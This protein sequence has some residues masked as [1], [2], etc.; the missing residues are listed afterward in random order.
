MHHLRQLLGAA[1]ALLLGDAL[2]FHREADVLQD[3][4]VGIERVVLEDKADAAL[5]RRQARHVAVVKENAAAAH[6]ENAGDHIQRCGLAAAARTEQGDELAAF[7]CDG[8]V[9]YGNGVAETLGQ[10]FEF[11][12][13]VRITSIF[14]KWVRRRH[15]ASSARAWRP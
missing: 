8:K 3:R 9:V 4:H 10:M 12:L 15:R 1:D 11:D 2:N 5:L 7:Q 14:R 6:G 13:H